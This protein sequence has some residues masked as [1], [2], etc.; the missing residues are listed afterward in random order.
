MPEVPT[1]LVPIIAIIIIGGV[2]TIFITSRLVKR[3][4]LA[5]ELILPQSMPSEGV[6]IPIIRAFTGIK[7]WGPLAIA[8]N[9]IKPQLRL[10]ESHMDYRVFIPKTA[11][12]GEIEQV[13]GFSSRYF[14]YMRFEFQDRSQTYTSYLVY[15]EEYRAVESF[16]RRKSIPVETR[17]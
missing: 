5:V 11:T 15:E 3:A 1:I 8:Q 16:L 14:N 4:K 17:N 7:G 10:F 6:E 13:V 12:Y 2:F 9:S